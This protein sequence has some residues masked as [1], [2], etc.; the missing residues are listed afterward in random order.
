MAGLLRETGRPDYRLTDRSMKHPLA[1]FVLATIL[2]LAAPRCPRRPAPTSCWSSPT[3]RATATSA[4]TAT[5]RSKRPTSTRS[6]PMGVRSLDRLPRRSDLL[7]DAKRLDERTL[8]DA[9]RSLAHDHGPIPDGGRRGHAGRAMF[10]AN[11]YRTGM[12]GKWHLGDNAPCRPQDQGFER[13]RVAPRRRRSARART[14][15]GND[16]FDDT[17]EV[18]GSWQKFDGYCTD[19]WFERGNRVHRGRRRRTSRSSSTCRRTRRTDPWTSSTRRRIHG[20]VPGQ[21]ACRRRWR[22]STG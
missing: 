3:T 2:S 17:Y 6:P 11:G 10:A 16:Y 4:R 5:P 12:F 14:T 1:L 21:R 7:A 22:S 19:V 9:H 8:F 15:W 20:P 13:V 18:D